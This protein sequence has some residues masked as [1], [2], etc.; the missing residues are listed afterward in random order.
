VYTLVL[1]CLSPQ[2]SPWFQSQS[3]CQ[4]SLATQMLLPPAAV[5]SP[6]S[7]WHQ[8][9]KTSVS[10]F[11]KKQWISALNTWKSYMEEI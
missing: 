6:V 9:I 11:S 4:H 10:R 7:L 5:D 2:L 1:L 8:E 3:T